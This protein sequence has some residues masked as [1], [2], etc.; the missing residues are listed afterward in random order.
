MKLL[1]GR[2]VCWYVLDFPKRYHIIYVVEG[3]QQHMAYVIFDH[4]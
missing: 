3:E 2:F 4:N 1:N